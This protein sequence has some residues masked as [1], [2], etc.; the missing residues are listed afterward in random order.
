[1]LDI[2]KSSVQLSMVGEGD[3]DADGKVIKDT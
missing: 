1:M 3:K 2:V